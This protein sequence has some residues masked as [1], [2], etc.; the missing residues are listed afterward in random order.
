MLSGESRRG[1]RISTGSSWSFW[2]S[3]KFSQAN[4][5]GF[6]FTRNAPANYVIL[7]L[8]ISDNDKKPISFATLMR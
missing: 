2:I 3:L 6:H 8:V 1:A 7:P 5:F 4:K